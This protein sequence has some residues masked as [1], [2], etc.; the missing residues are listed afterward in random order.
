VPTERQAKHY[1][2][3]NPSFAIKPKCLLIYMESITNLWHGG[4]QAAGIIKALVYLRG[5]HLM[6]L[7][8]FG[9]MTA[10]DKAKDASLITMLGIREEQENV[11]TKHA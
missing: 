5:R 3:K 8:K 11:M 2:S 7:G 1:Y 6:R 10:D 9:V 4:A